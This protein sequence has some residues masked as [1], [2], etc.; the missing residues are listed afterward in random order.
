MIIVIYIH[1]CFVAPCISIPL[2]ITCINR[3]AICP[4]FWFEGTLHQ[5]SLTDHDCLWPN[6]DASKVLLAC[7]VGSAKTGWRRKWSLAKYRFRVPR[8]HCR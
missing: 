2:H 1:A 7:P 4:S 5:T 6:N 3:S 8:A